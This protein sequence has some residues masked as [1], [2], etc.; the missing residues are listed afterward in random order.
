MPIVPGAEPY[1]HDGGPTGVLLCHGLTG[2]P[3]SLRPW[4]EHLA[5]AGLTVEVPL[6]PGHGTTWQELNATRWPDWY[7]AVERSMLGLR[8][9]CDQVVV[10][11]L[12][13]GGCLALRLAQ[14]YG[15][16]ISGLVLVNP[17]IA[18]RDRRLRAL[19]LLHRVVPSMS[20][21]S[22]DI[23]KPG[24]DEIA[25][26]RN[27]L[28]ALH[29][30]TQLW[31]LVVADLPRVTQPM[32]IYRSSQDHVVDATSVGLITARVSSTDVTVV[33]LPDCYHVATLDYGAETIFAGSLDLIRRL[34]HAT[35]EGG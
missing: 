26:D 33:T 7:A 4:A 13:M 29:S 16:A 2:S 14:A 8:E 19:P 28:R 15:D 24:Q 32:L 23:A 31:K 20:A 34:E 30:L 22:G 35:R 27:P 9:R 1:R 6:L 17:A 5:A 12:S 18:S 11:G 21:L 3:A 10:G 25:Y